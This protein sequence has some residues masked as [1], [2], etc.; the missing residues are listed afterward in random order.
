MCNQLVAAWHVGS[1]IAWKQKWWRTDSYMHLSRSGIFEHFYNVAARRTA[2]NRIID[3][4]NT[5][6]TN[7]F[8]QGIQFN[9]Y[10]G[11]T[12]RLFGFNKRSSHITVLDKTNA[13]RNI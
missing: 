9:V 12:G 6:A 1:K 13:I 10:T 11:L 7:H 2:H 5:L 8:F 4:H 3:H